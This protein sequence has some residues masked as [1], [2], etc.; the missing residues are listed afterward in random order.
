MLV[1]YYYYFFLFALT[2]FLVIVF[3][4]KRKRPAVISR[5][6]ETRKERENERRVRWILQ[7]GHSTRH[8]ADP[9]RLHG[10]EEFLRLPCQVC[11]AGVVTKAAL[12]ASGLTNV[13]K[14]E[15]GPVLGMVFLFEE[16]AATEERWPG[17]AGGPLH[18]C[19][20]GARSVHSRPRFLP[21]R[22][23]AAPSP[24]D[25]GRRRRGLPALGRD[26]G[27][28]VNPGSMAP[29]CVLERPLP[30]PS[31]SNHS[32]CWWGECR[33]P[34]PSPLLALS[35]TRPD[36]RGAAEHPAPGLGIRSR[37]NAQQ[38][39]VP[40]LAPSF[41]P[42][43]GQDRKD[44]PNKEKPQRVWAFSRAHGLDAIGTESIAHAKEAGTW[45]GT[46]V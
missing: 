24:K 28:W 23:G 38:E 12:G 36:T 20:P 44:G 41:Q 35:A 14:Q 32:S 18:S 4:C 37:G 3:H 34:P 11:Y 39:A 7:S 9:R 30:P 10:T 13:C 29:E 15:E 31:T 17:C 2:N 8:T 45:N 21:A 40:F 1:N 26:R 25:T 5:K 33:S 6:R 27:P 42:F 22:G 19:W 43:S 46:K 16:K